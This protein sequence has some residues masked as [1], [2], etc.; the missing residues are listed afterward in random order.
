[1]I[2]R[3]TNIGAL[4]QKIKGKLLKELQRVG[5][6]PYLC[7]KSQVVAILRGS[8]RS[9]WPRSSRPNQKRTPKHQEVVRVSRRLTMTLSS[10]LPQVKGG[11]TA[12]LLN[13]PNLQKE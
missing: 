5:R 3:V 8:P 2:V 7:V 13:P 9:L 10:Q 11:L 4:F 12:H 6:Q 1:M